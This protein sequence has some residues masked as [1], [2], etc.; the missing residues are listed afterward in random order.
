MDTRCER[1]PFDRQPTFA[2]QL[3][4]SPSK[5]ALGRPRLLPTTGATS[6]PLSPLRTR[7]LAGGALRARGTPLPRMPHQA[8]PRSAA[9]KR[10][11]AKAMKSRNTPTCPIA[12]LC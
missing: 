8:L 7:A 2:A 10:G 5:I 11:C 9:S 6:A 12:A 3:A 1:E 4:N